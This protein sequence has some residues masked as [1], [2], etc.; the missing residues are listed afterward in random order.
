[1]IKTVYGAR[2]SSS[3][4]R[5]AH[6]RASGFLSQIE[7]TGAQERNE[8]REKEFAQARAEA[9][10]EARNYRGR[11]KVDAFNLLAPS[12]SVTLQIGRYYPKVGMIGVPDI[13]KDDA[14]GAV[15]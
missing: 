6:D 3:L 14:I 5:S 2:W 15:A 4:N 8:E 9:E 11:A 7:G 12:L 13:L 1:M 10:K